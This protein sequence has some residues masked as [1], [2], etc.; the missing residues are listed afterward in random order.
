MA[1]I[2]PQTLFVKTDKGHLQI[3][4][5]TLDLPRE[6]GLVFLSVDGKTSAGDLLTRSGM[7]AGAFYGALETLIKAKAAH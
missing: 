3:R 6:V 2:S 7:S 4:N 5:R 1:E